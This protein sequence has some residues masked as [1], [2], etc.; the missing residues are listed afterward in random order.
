MVEV[1]GKTIVIDTGP[2]FRQQ[3]LRAKP[4]DV[5][6]VIYT[7]EHKD[8]IAG[9]DDVRAFNFKHHKAMDLYATQEV[10][11]AIK[12]EFH[13]IFSDMK[14]PGV[15]EVK[16][17][18]IDPSVPFRVSGIEVIPLLVYHYKMPVL[19][20]R[21]GNMAYI[22][23]ASS[24]PANVMAQLQGLDV[25]VLDALRRQSHISHFSLQQA[26]SIS[27]EL[28]PARTYFTHISHLMGLHSEVSA[29]LPPNVFLGYDML[30][31]EV[32]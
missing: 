32:K 7:H 29:E 26:I 4:H 25:L 28:K 9:L 20:F 3:M 22:T 15:P 1:D 17:L 19:G 21:I 6:A 10:Q 14:Y 27:E 5:D 16:L 13:Y 12:R 18:D 11:N 31:L 2:D 23:D 24:I 8:H 30:S